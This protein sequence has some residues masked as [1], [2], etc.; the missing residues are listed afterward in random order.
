MA[1]HG[2]AQLALGDIRPTELEA[3]KTDLLAEMPHIE[4]LTLEL[5]VR[6][7]NSVAQV[8]AKT[9][10]FGRID[11]AINNAGISGPFSPTER[12]PWV[13]WE[14]MYNVNIHGTWRCQKHELQQMVQQDYRETK[15]GRLIE[16]LN[17]S[18]AADQTINRPGHPLSSSKGVIINVASVL[19][20]LGSSA[21]NP[22]AAYSSTK[23]AVMGLTKTVRLVSE[24]VYHPV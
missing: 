6:S 22:A 4:V 19:G 17:P 18:K 8:V 13:E 23:H 16:L 2:I 7:E 24:A 3:T 12:T 20:L 5:D 21:Q 10:T 1:R 11:V 9:T 14:Q 15:C